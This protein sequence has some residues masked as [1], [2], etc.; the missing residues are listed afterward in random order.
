MSLIDKGNALVTVRAKVAVDDGYGGT[1][2]GPGPAV[3]MRVTLSPA[4]TSSEA[5]HG[6]L[7]ESSYTLS[8]RSLPDEIYDVT[9]DGGRWFPEGEVRQHI[10]PTRVAFDSVLITQQN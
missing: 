1:Q 4:S 2:P 9:W 3:E 7:T 8:A 6:Y 10:G 5:A